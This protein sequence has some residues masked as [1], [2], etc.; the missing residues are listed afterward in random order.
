MMI[1]LYLYLLSAAVVVKII[2]DDLR[3]K[4]ELLTF[5]NLFLL[6][7]VYFCALGVARPMKLGTNAPYYLSSPEETGRIA[8]IATTVLVIVFITAYDRA[9][10][11]D[12]IVKLLPSSSRA[13]SIGKLLIL[14][15]VMTAIGFAIRLVRIPIVSSVADYAGWGSAAIACGIVGWIWAPRLYNPMVAVIGT[16]IVGLNALNVLNGAFGRRTLLSIFLGLMW[17]M[18]F[19]HFR[20]LPKRKYL[21]YLV[22]FALAGLVFVGMYSSSREA[23]NFTR[24]TT[25][26]LQA[27]A[28]QGDP[29]RGFTMLTE[30]S[31][32]GQLTLWIIEN[33]PGNYEHRHLYT[34]KYYLYLPIPRAW[35]EE[36]P[37][38]LSR[39]L[40]AMTNRRG[41]SHEQLSLGPG[42]VGQAFAEGGWYALII[43]AIVFAYIWRILQ[44][45][46]Y[47]NPRNLFVILPLGA[48]LAQ[49]FGV[50][51]G[52]VSAF[53]FA[54]S[55]SVISTFMIMWMLA[56]VLRFE[57]TESGEIV[58]PLATARSLELEA[59][60][61][62]PSACPVCAAP[63]D[64]ASAGDICPAC[65]AEIDARSAPRSLAAP[66]EVARS[67]GPPEAATPHASGR[68]RTNGAASGS[69][70]RRDWSEL[71]GVEMAA[72][73]E[74]DRNGRHGL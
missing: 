44:E 70:V 53:F 43:Y 5:R 13:P 50:P 60:A 3:G 55:V 11:V 17:G 29:I 49:T 62:G 15:F 38:P 14:A 58:A 19:S 21:P 31:D 16:V 9:P 63:L 28:T 33:I 6:G 8:A 48:A 30:G 34:L 65:G 36:K 1:A 2:V 25:E 68:D 7:I 64:P 41:V 45:W 12:R 32:A 46:I 66:V 61:V 18:Y 73:S 56:K 72:E 40:P 37:M 27:M 20:Y 47:K 57:R 39:L 67:S 52:E 10:G 59:A 24:T 51:R 26:Q 22:P 71:S 23:G 69:T 42:F 35:W 54:Y 4:V 74:R